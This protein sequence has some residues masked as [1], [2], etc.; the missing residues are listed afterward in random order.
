MNHGPDPK[1]QGQQGQFYSSSLSWCGVFSSGKNSDM[2]ERVVRHQ[3]GLPRKA[4]DAPSLE[5]FRAREHRALSN[6][7]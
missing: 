4:V 3:K 6:L 7:V 2:D 1:P 5:V